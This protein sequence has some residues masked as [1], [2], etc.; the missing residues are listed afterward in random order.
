[1]K[2]IFAMCVAAIMI[3]SITMTSFATGDGVS[4]LTLGGDTSLEGSTL[5]PGYEYSYPVQLI[6]DG[7]PADL[8]EDYM[9]DHRLS[10]SV[11][12]GGSLISSAQIEK[13]DGEYMLVLS[14]GGGALQAPTAVGIELQLRSQGESEPKA[15]L[16][17]SFMVG[18]QAMDDDYLEGIGAGERIEISNATPLIT[19]DQ[20]AMLSRNSEGGTL[21]FAGDGW[22]YVI[23]PADLDG[24]NFM[25]SDA[26]ISDIE[27]QF[28]E[29]GRAIRY[30]RFTAG[31][32]MGATGE[33]TIDVSGN[34]DDFDG[35]YYVY[36]YVYDRMYRYPASYDGAEG[37][38]SFD[39]AELDNFI[40]TNMPITEG[41]IVNGD[42]DNSMVA[43]DE[44]K[45]P[46]TGSREVVG[47][48]VG[49]GLIALV[50]VAVLRK[51]TK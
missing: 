48:A 10:V 29:E 39:A 42:S 37:T 26:E 40:I 27:S 21:H 16:E 14:A 47:I 43:G 23:D 20:L 22:N 11:E 25:F 50:A 45:N 35:K 12:K 49:A 19:D 17:A 38:V 8:T 41:T 33:V 31:V 46:D 4:G 32:D 5:K 51:R 15:T 34:P 24:V 2:R 28:D 44:E 18:W 30:V 13:Q 9:E 1:M 7:N 6:I 36:R 3:M